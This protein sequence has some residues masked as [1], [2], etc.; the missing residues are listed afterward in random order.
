MNMCSKCLIASIL[1]NFEKQSS[2]G[3][4]KTVLI[5][6]AEIEFGVTNVIQ[7]LCDKQV[8]KLSE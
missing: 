2:T 1:Q 7:E 6:L 8:K 5:L 4:T 3:K